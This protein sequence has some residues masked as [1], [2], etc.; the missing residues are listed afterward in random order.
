MAEELKAGGPRSGSVFLDACRRKAVP[1]TPIWVMRQA[2]RYLPEYRELRARVDFAA[3]TRSAELAAE[4][5]L[6]PLRRFPLDA[7]ILFSDIM[8]PL[9]GMGIALDFEPGPVV[10]EPIR[11]Q[12]QVQALPE[13]NPERDVPFVM[14]AIRLIRANVPRNTPLIG[15]A[16]APF[17]LLCYLVSGRPSKE[18]AAAR[19]F[20]YSQPETAERLLDRLADAMSAY[21]RAQ[22]Q[23]GAQALM[24]FESWAGLLA[25]TEFRRFAL[26]AAR[27]T[28]SALRSL[29]VPLIYYANQGSALMQAIGELDVDVVGVDW[30]TPLSTARQ[31]LGPDKA[32]QGNLDPAALFAAPDDLRRHADA[33]LEQAG[34]APGHIFNLGHG[35]WPDTDPD[36]VSRL[37]DHVHERSARQGG[38]R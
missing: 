26:R 9:Q 23:A 10:R 4:V 24:L 20:L 33:V 14:D 6:Q 1:Y 36:Q 19:S 35:I 38:Q 16:G 13:L 28:M 21:L 12:A 32:V 18:F 3:L 15:F 2:G 11:T 37:I 22:A 25:P 7:A 34:S 27:R 8:T 29:D 31:I 5:T 30:R 17:T